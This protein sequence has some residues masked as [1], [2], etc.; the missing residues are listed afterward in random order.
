MNPLKSAISLYRL[1]ADWLGEGG[2]PVESALIEARTQ[3]CL[4]CP[5]NLPNPILERALAPVIA[6]MLRLQAQMQL[7]A[8]DVPGLHI[9]NACDCLLRFKVKVPIKH[10]LKTTPLEALQ[11]ENPVCWILAERSSPEI[12]SN[13]LV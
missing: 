3:T 12:K 6:K 5:Q 9:C 11:K 2:V 8:N 7:A 1:R 4:Q 13:P 10:I